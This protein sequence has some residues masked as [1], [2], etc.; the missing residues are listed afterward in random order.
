MGPNVASILNL[1]VYRL[2]YASTLV[3]CKSNG[4]ME[5]N[6]QFAG[7]TGVNQCEVLGK[8]IRHLRRLS[9]DVLVPQTIKVCC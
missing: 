7:L 4:T 3:P 6:G 5:I 9:F 1:A 2:S 8:G